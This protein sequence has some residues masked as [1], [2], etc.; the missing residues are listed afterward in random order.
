MP[1]STS[2][3][4]AAAAMQLDQQSLAQRFA[5]GNP[6]AFEEVIALHRPRITRLV[7][8]LLGWPADVDDMVQ[9]VF[10]AAFTKCHRFRGDSSLATWLTVIALNKCRSHRR[11]LLARLRTLRRASHR[12]LPPA[13]S[14][15]A[16]AM[17]DD[18]LAQVRES[19]R[20]LNPRDREVIVLH[21][22]EDKTVTE[23]STLL[24]TKHNTIEVRLHRARQH[25]KTL[26]QPLIDKQK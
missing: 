8:R 15:D 6:A 22:L 21:Y 11:G 9:E 13:S 20:K 10:L 23:I 1:T 5:L 18:T 24:K 7:Y 14:A 17:L 12:P 3:K 19:I 16:A 2:L 25:L 4:Q 26:L